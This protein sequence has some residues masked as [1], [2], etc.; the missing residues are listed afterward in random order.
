MS[1]QTLLNPTDL[2]AGQTAVM[3]NANAKRVTPRLV[4]RVARVVPPRDLFLSRSMEEARDQVH[5]VVGRGYQR[6]LSGGGDGTLM[7]VITTVDRVVREALS[8]GQEVEPP[9][10]GVL[11]LGTGNAVATVLG[12]GRTTDDVLRHLREDQSTRVYLDMIRSVDDDTLCPFTGIGYDGEILNDYYWFKERARSPLS[13]LLMQTSLG[14]LGSFF[15]RTFPRKL[16]EIGRRKPEARVVSLGRAYRVEAGDRIVPVDNE[17]LYE[18]PVGIVAAGSVPYYGF[19]FKMFPFAGRMP[20]FLHLRVASIG[21]VTAVMNL[22]QVWSGAFRHPLI[23][24]FLVE[25]VRVEG[26][27]PLPY[28]LGGDA[29]GERSTLHLRTGENPVAMA[30]LRP[31]PLALP[32]A[33]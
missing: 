1:L 18:G 8:R 27:R 15:L 16:A 5:T 21:A 7:H 31:L 6:L 23:Q 19:R 24:E 25:E 26:E 14:Y 3:L 12:A 11:R 22:R 28:Q 20:G 4:E 17:L 2:C 10:I 33:A 13:R 29:F 9:E 32:A 30:A